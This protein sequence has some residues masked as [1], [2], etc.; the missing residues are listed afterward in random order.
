MYL[1]GFESEKY[2]ILEVLDRPLVFFWRSI[3]IILLALR[4]AP[5][6]GDCLLIVEKVCFGFPAC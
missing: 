3:D 4:A 1:W 5:D 6:V 2:I